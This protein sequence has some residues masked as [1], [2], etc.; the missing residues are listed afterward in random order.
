V[1]PVF[2]HPQK[3]MYI[4]CQLGG[5]RMRFVAKKHLCNR[6]ALIGRERGDIK[7]DSRPSRAAS[8][9]ATPK[10]WPARTT[11]PLVRS[12]ARVKAAT[13]LAN[14]VSGIAAQ[15]TLTPCRCNGRMMLFQQDLSAH[16]PCTRTIVEF[17]GTRGHQG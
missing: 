6:L 15:I 16:A 3:A 8:I 1:K 4:G 7:R 9:T 2:R 5:V 17:S 12:S 14:D 10:E 13:S 11:G